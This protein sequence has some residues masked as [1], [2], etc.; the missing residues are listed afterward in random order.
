MTN[1]LIIKEINTLWNSVSFSGTS[2]ARESNWHAFESVTGD[3]SNS[4][5]K[6]SLFTVALQW[7]LSYVTS[8]RVFPSPSMV[9]PM[10]RNQWDSQHYPINSYVHRT[11]ENGKPQN[12]ES[13][14]GGSGTLGTWEDTWLGKAKKKAPGE[15]ISHLPEPDG[16]C[17][18]ELS[19]SQRSQEAVSHEAIP[20]IQSDEQSS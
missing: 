20:R 16:W 17:C 14:W 9:L 15:E 18:L 5:Q 7:E 13:P 12:T 1:S 10:Q 19:L 11:W 2:D 4:P 3:Q 6:L 8:L